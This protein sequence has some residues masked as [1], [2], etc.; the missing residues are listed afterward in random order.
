MAQLIYHLPILQFLLPFLGALLIVIVSSKTTV[1]VI[2]TLCSCASIIAAA[3]G[4]WQLDVPL[5][6]ALGGWRA[7][8]GIEFFLDRYNE[9]LILL[10]S[11]VLF[12]LAIAARTFLQE[13][14]QY[15]K[16]EHSRLLYVFILLVHAG[17]VGILSTNDLFNL[18]V[19]IE[20]VSLAT[21]ALFAIGSKEKAV[22][23]LDYLIMSTIAATFILVGIGVIFSQTGHLNMELVAQW[24]TDTPS[25]LNYLA[26]TFIFLGTGAKLGLVPV[27]RWLIGCYKF[28]LAPLLIYLAISS[29]V[30]GIYIF[31]KFIFYI[32]KSGPL[33]KANLACLLQIAGIIT[34]LISSIAALRAEGSLSLRAIVANSAVAQTGYVILILGVPSIYNMNL[35]IAMLV[36]DSITKASLFYVIS[37]IDKAANLQYG[38]FE[39]SKSLRYAI[40][41]VI[42]IS[43]GLPITSGFI[44]KFTILSTLFAKHSYY[45]F[46]LVCTAVFLAVMYHYKLV[47][48]LYFRAEDEAKLDQREI[49][50]IN[51]NNSEI[52]TLYILSLCSFSAIWLLL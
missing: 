26:V 44:I 52:C 20:I 24:F 15:I 7:P 49:V 40:G 13:A 2:F 46:V 16:Q 14:E 4:V 36:A 1:R 37:I 45:L 19:F 8:I 10:L 22:K 6:Y 27:N 48:L 39:L 34:I 12:T 11:F 18:Y 35:I 21:C 17:A 42:F 32:L 41:F 47:K 30:T 5:Y 31:F 51:A 28:A 43:S 33:L 9:I 29:G 25:P 38:S 3:L 50:I 23:A